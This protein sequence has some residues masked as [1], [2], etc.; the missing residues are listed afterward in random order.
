MRKRFRSCSS[1]DRRR[2]S[3]RS[4]DPALGETHAN[5]A[6]GSTKVDVTATAPVIPC[7]SRM[8]SKREGY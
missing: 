5:R 4:P 7:L 2:G 1:I 6:R 3:V 8:T